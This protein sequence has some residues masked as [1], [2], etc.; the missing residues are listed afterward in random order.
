[1]TNETNV[2][3]ILTQI[4]T[5]FS[6]GIN[7]D[8]S[9]LSYRYIYS[10]ALGVRARLLSQKSKN[11]QTISDSSYST[12]SCIEVIEVPLSECPFM[13]PSN[14]RV[15]RTKLK[16]PKII[17]D[18]NSELIKYVGAIEPINGVIVEF[19]KIDKNRLKYQKGSKFAHS[20]HSYYFNDGYLYLQG[21]NIPR[22][23]ELIGVVL[24]PFEAELFNCT[25]CGI[26]DCIT[27][28]DI[29]FKIDWEIVQS[30]TLMT[31]E[32]ILTLFGQLQRSDKNEDNV[33]ENQ[34]P[35]EYQNEA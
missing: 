7:S 14:C 24:D 29:D 32:T 4:Q 11:K 23:I 18:H 10:K 12:F 8:S 17:S 26:D 16:L 6:K 22:F 34:R 30:L 25:S 13:P 31:A 3:N 35:K 2:G 33:D 20:I 21:R 27:P 15:A 5:E 9:Q 1:M 19:N 28:Y